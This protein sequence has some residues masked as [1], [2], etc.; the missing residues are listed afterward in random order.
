MARVTISDVAAAS[1]VSRTTVS[2]VLNKNPTQTISPQTQERVRRAAAALGYTP[3]GTARALREGT[4]RIVVLTVEAGME[5]NYSRSYVRGLDAELAAHGHVL[6]VRHGASAE[7]H[8]SVVEAVTPRAVLRLGEAYHRP[9]RELDDGGWAN[10]LAANVALQLGHLADRGHRRIAVAFPGP[11]PGPDAGPGEVMRDVRVRFA[12]EAA[13]RAGLTAVHAVTLS[14][15]HATRAGQVRGLLSGSVPVS[16][17]A[18]F[19][20]AVALRVLRTLR[21]LGL[22]APDDLAVIGFDESEYAALSVP[23]LSTVHIDAESHGRTDA[24]AVLDLDTGDTEHVPG[25]LVVREST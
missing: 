14:C 21:D 4:S 20:D 7:S 15:D 24:R 12:R 17:V 3:H 10:G 8:R 25:R 16:A 5:G 2:F 19:D 13:T 23:G 22:R 9:G 6:L 1:G 11:G 18:A